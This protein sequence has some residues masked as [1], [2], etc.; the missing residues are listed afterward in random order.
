MKHEML[1]AAAP[2]ERI[3]SGQKTIELR[4]WDEKRQKIKVGHTL[5]FHLL[6]TPET[7][8]TAKVLALH[9]FDSFAQLYEQLDLLACGYTLDNIASA[10][11]EDMARYC[12]AEQE[13]RY[14]VVGIEI[15]VLDET[16]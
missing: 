9:R 10:K 7:T 2:F 14:G 8:L 13:A 15:E 6:D 16:I 5:V 1:L 3:A 12:S 11:P 4:L